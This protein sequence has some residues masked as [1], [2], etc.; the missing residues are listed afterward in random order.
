MFE[1]VIYD[2]KTEQFLNSLRAKLKV[3][4]LF[5]MALSKKRKKHQQMS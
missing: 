3:K 5:L 4:T 2:E 1:A